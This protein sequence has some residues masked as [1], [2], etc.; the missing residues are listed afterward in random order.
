MAH[1]ARALRRMILQD[2]ASEVITGRRPRRTADLVTELHSHVW[3]TEQAPKALPELDAATVTP[4][5]FAEAT[6]GLTHPVLIR[7]FMK[8]IGA[9]TRW[10][11]DYLSEKCGDTPFLAMGPTD[12]SDARAAYEVK[13]QLA[14]RDFIARMADEPLYVSASTE[15][16]A[17]HPDMLDALDLERIQERLTGRGLFDELVNTQLFMG[18]PQVWTS[19]HCAPAGNVFVQL[20]GR[21]K[22]VLIDPAYSAA[23][24]PLPPRPFQY[25]MSAL[26]GFQTMR[27]LGKEPGILANIP[28]YET[29][30]EPGDV[31]YNTP[32]WW[33]EVEN[34][35]PLTLGC[36][37][38][39]A[40]QPGRYGA[41]W[42]NNLLFTS[43]SNYPVRRGQ[44]VAMVLAARALGRPLDMLEIAN[45]GTSRRV[46]QSFRAEQGA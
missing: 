7:G 11:G 16:F 26:G 3:P 20:Q 32:W 42:K 14:L 5:S 2:F 9:V 24:H 28:R 40:P 43:L 34:L 13:E 41:N 12:T 35:D 23:M 37:I 25:A 27:R 15:L 39:H 38:R 33:H 36:A 19:L 29:I 22:W 8:H 18:S 6:R 4:A 30:L 31:L 44:M 45:A 1:S 17:Q 10:N 21:K 46:H